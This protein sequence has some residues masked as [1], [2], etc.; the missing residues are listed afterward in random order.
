MSSS[1]D[2]RDLDGA[3]PWKLLGVGRSAGAEEIK[4]SYRRLSR[5]HHADVGGDSTQQVRLNR[6]YEILS[7]PTRRADYALLL[8]RKERPQD[9]VRPTPEPEPEEPAADPFAW[10]SGPAPTSTP[11]RYEQPYQDPYTES[12]YADPPYRDSYVAPPYRDSYTTSTYQPQRRGVSGQAVGAVLT[13]FICSP[14][15]IYLA[16]SVL[17]NNRPGRALAW[18]AIL[19]NVGLLGFSIV[20]ALV[21]GT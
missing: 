3:D 21:R 1:R 10:S 4:R 5:S 2:F 16:I 18:L 11:P 15:S 9:F 6:A 12:P 13:A 14:V 20:G 19:I 8:Q 7:D 17:R